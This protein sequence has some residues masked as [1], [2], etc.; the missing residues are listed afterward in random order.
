MD[1]QG[2]IGLLGRRRSVRR[3]K[4]D[5]VSR[6]TLEKILEASRY[7]PS[8]GNSQP[9]ELVVVQDSDVKRDISRRIALQIRE[10]VKTDPTIARGIAV[11]P[12][13]YTAPVLIVVCGDPRLQ[14]SYPA[15]MDRSAL[16]RQSLSNCIYTVQLAAACFGLATAWATVQKGQTELIV[17][18]ILGIPE[19]YTVDHLVPLGYPDDEAEGGQPVLRRVKERSGLRRGLGE[20]VHYDRYDTRRFRTDEEVKE[21][22]W[23]STV[24]RMREEH[25]R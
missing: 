14:E 6:E 9:W 7:A 21:F 11:Q 17:K 18:E 10:E 3:F 19:V 23:S 25:D 24:T 1:Y 12:F 5:P 13:L 15:W 2:F 8:A 4:P 22:I 16:L 20:V